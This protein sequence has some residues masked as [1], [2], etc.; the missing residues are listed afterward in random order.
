MR[1][2]LT[3]LIALSAALIAVLIVSYLLSQ[4][5]K[6][7]IAECQADT[8]FCQTQSGAQLTFAGPI[9][10]NQPLPLRLSFAADDAPDVTQLNV[11]LT[12]KDMYMGITET[13]L[14]KQGQGFEGVLRIPI[15]TT[16]KMVWQMTIARPFEGSSQAQFEPLTYQ[17]TITQD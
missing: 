10:V 6:V 2:P 4:P 5:D 11:R 14:V 9:K 3:K 16:E 17:F 1:Y 15:C 12:G 13:T 7:A 8:G